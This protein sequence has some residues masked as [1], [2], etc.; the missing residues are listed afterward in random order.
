MMDV[1]RLDVAKGLYG[2]QVD[3]TLYSSAVIGNQAAI[4]LK[5]LAVAK[6]SLEPRDRA[7]QLTTIRTATEAARPGHCRKEGRPQEEVSR[8]VGP[9]PL[10]GT[11]VTE[12]QFPS[13]PRC[14]EA[15]R[16]T[17]CGGGPPTLLYVCTPWGK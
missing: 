3:H 8:S 2:W 10:R 4:D 1:G 5:R 13:A 15:S 16:P 7:L 9:C 11:E 14:P 6:G 12:G 17:G